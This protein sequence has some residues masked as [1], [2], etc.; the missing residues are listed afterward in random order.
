MDTYAAILTAIEGTTVV[1]AAKARTTFRH[2]M[3]RLVAASV[4]S[5]ALYIRGIL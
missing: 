1:A 5:V 2:P 4:H 3:E